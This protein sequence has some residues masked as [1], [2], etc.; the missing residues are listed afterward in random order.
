MTVSLYEASVPQFLRML[1][2]LSAMLAKAE[3]HAA[4]SGLDPAA[5]I[6]ARLAPDMFPLA[7]QVQIATDGVK[8]CAARMA[9]ME[10][11]SF[12]DTETTFPELRE[13]IGKTADFLRAVPEAAFEGAES[14]T[15]GFKLRGTEMSFS[16]GAYLFGFVLPNFYFHLTTAYTILRHKGIEVGKQDF[17]GKI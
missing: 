3:A 12:P 1:E 17:L 2:N 8:A 7:R 4:A 16:A 13:R 10:T 9:C 11:P 14:R 6:E 15:I 5:L